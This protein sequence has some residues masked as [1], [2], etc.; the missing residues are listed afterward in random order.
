MSSLLLMV[1]GEDL[2]AIEEQLHELR[3]LSSLVHSQEGVCN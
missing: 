2:F 3:V 1:L